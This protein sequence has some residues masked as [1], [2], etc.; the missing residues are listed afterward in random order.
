MS[1]PEPVQL[2]QIDSDIN[3]HNGVSTLRV[4]VNSRIP[5]VASG[6]EE[7]EV[8]QIVD[9]TDSTEVEELALAMI[10]NARLITYN[11][12]CTLKGERVEAWLLANHPYSPEAQE[13]AKKPHIAQYLKLTPSTFEAINRAADAATGLAE[14][15]AKTNGKGKH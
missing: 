6:T 2:D 13:A 1:R 7:I 9:C 3:N 8:E 15:V 5:T 11:I 4:R 12:A 10:Q 14:V